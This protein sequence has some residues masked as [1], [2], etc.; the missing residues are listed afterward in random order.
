[1]NIFIVAMEIDTCMSFRAGG[2]MFCGESCLAASHLSEYPNSRKSARWSNGA[3]N[4]MLKT[5]EYVCSNNEFHFVQQW[6]SHFA[7]YRLPAKLRSYWA[8]T[9]STDPISV[10][11]VSRRLSNKC[12][13]SHQY[14]LRYTYRRERLSTPRSEWRGVRFRYHRSRVEQRH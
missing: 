4:Y 3:Q 9:T 14:A 2:R 10:L 11:S 7:N 1:M 13:N 6:I 8:E 12:A 5:L